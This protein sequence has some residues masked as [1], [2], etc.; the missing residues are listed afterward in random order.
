MKKEKQRLTRFA[1]FYMLNQ[2]KDFDCFLKD[3]LRSDPLPYD[4]WL[5]L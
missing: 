2:I 1:C 3:L 5:A 4:A